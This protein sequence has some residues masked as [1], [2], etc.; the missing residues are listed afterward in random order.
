MLKQFTVV[1]LFVCFFPT[2]IVSD[3]ARGDIIDFTSP[4]VQQNGS[5]AGG[6][7]FEE[8]GFHVE[9]ILWNGRDDVFE[10]LQF[11]FSDGAAS[12]SEPDNGIVIER[13]DGGLFDL[14][15]FGVTFGF[16]PGSADAGLVS[17]SGALNPGSPNDQNGDFERLQIDLSLIHI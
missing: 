5:I 16:L 9:R 12:F 17:I 6:E 3:C 2:L 11:V 4:V 14:E 1:A 13:I 7:F 15:S 8:D 10:G